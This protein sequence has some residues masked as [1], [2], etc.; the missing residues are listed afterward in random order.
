ME[1]EEGGQGQ[2]QGRQTHVKK[3]C[4]FR[5]GL[6][7]AQGLKFSTISSKGRGGGVNVKKLQNWYFGASLTDV[8]L[9]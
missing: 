2:G 8:G 4:R 3:N 9:R 6:T 7:N 5:K 1:E